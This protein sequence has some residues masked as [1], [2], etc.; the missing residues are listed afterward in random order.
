MKLGLLLLLVTIMA[1]CASNYGRYYQRNDSAPHSLP[2]NI[3]L[4][5][6]VPRYEAHYPASLRQYSVLGKTYTP[7]NSEQA[8][9]YSATGQA[10]WYGQKF[11]GHLTAN[12]ETYDMYQMS[13]AH[14]T[15]PLP[16]YARITNLA[17]NKQ[18]IVRIND[19]GPFHG[20]RLLD[21]SYAA[22]KKLDMLK[23]GVADIRLD[24]ITVDQQGNML[25]AGKPLASKTTNKNDKALYIQVAALQDSKRINQ[26]AKGLTQLYQVAAQTPTE[27]GLFRLRLGPLT[28]EKSANDLLQRLK[29]EGYP[30]AFT[31]YAPE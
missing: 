1:G 14:K 12:G 21:M 29:K 16:S 30:N 8:K 24:V 27:N 31:L 19:R 28:D 9:R 6:A 15:L 10:S 25:V 22:A 17:N 18:V 20:H 4:S 7:M 26:I 2:D 5:D 23:H 11:H 3:S 13:A